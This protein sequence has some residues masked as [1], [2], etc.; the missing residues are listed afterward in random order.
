MP[1]FPH[2]GSDGRS[3]RALDCRHGRVLFHMYHE[4]V[5]DLLVWNPVN[6][7]RRA[8]PE[9]DI[10]WMAYTAAVFCAADGCWII[11]DRTQVRTGEEG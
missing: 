9:P 6:G 5:M 10:D 11:H 1:D 2:P 3:T 7:D 8:V 4:H